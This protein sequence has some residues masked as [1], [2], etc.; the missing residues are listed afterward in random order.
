MDINITTSNPTLTFSYI[1]YVAQEILV[2]SQ[3]VVNLT[4]KEDINQLDEIV[5]IDYGYG[6]VKKNDMTGSVASISST[7]LAKI[8]VSSAA[9]AISGRLPGVNVTA[10]DGEPG[11]EIRIRVRGGGSITQDNS[12][13]YVV[14]GFIVSSITDIPPSDIASIDVLKDAYAVRRNG[15]YKR[16]DL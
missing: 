9:E 8:P 10:S 15:F 11:A 14:D 6:K 12:P 2:G 4:M 1:G 3:K 16:K 5:L 7:E 13:L